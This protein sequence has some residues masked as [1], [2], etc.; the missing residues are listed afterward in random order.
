MTDFSDAFGA[1]LG[2]VLGFD[3]DLA[4]IVGLCSASAS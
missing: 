4:E 2:L 1:A 3:A